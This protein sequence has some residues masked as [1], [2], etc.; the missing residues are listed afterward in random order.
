MKNLFLRENVPFTVKNNAGNEF[1][2][3]QN[4]CNS[5]LTQTLRYTPQADINCNVLSTMQPQFPLP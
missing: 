3:L 5:D 4:G 2:V 1:A